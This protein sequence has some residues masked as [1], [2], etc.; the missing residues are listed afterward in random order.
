M[1]HPPEVALGTAD[2]ALAQE[3]LVRTTDLATTVL[4]G[5]LGAAVAA[6]IIGASLVVVLPAAV[7]VG[8]VGVLAARRA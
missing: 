8:L 6:F 7:G 5:A 3:T 4:A 2:P 1:R